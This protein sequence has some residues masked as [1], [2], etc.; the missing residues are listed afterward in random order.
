MTALQADATTHATSK[1]LKIILQQL[2]TLGG[3]EMVNR[4]TRLITAMALAWALSPAEFGL[5][6]IA[7]TTS[8]VL[9]ALTQTGIGARIIS[10]SDADLTDTCN[11]A[12]RLNWWAYGLVAI[13]QVAIA[14]PVASHFGDS[15]IAWLLCALSLPYWLYPLVAVQV[16]RVQRQSRMRETAMMLLV[17]ITGDNLLTALLAVMGWGLMSLAVPKLI[18]AAVWV[19]A[20][21]RLE[22]WKPDSTY[23]KAQT[24]PTLRFGL[25]VL[26]SELL[27]AL[28]LHADKLVV[29][30]VLG[31]AVLGQY[32]FAFNAGL[33]ISSALL[34]VASAALLPYY[35]KI[36][37]L[38]HPA[39]R[40]VSGTVLLYVFLLPVIG[41]Q[42]IL[43]PY[44][45]PIV[46]GAKWAGTVHI[47][48]LLCSCAIPLVLSRSTSIFLRSRNKIRLE[49]KASACHFLSGMLVLLCC[50]HM[51]FLFAICLLLNRRSK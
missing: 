43:A 40:F 8:E 9:R 12:Y 35:S 31:L 5:A 3:A 7:L 44:Y 15:R 32:Y 29:G 25:G 46:F 19:L 28:R 4:I 50:I 26:L 47:L 37:A 22:S 2:V 39:Q 38:K 16:Y 14:F 33:G 13:A 24:L 20:Y 11:A 6:A 49:L 10:T 42:I 1:P 51:G 27:Q 41:L 17:L 18:C 23:N 48:V 21:R 36:D 30:H 45:V 34:T